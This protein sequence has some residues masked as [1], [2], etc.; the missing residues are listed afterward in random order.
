[1][2]R[3]RLAST[4]RAVATRLADEPGPL[5]ALISRAEGELAYRLSRIAGRLRCG[6]AAPWSSSTTLC[7]V[8][9]RLFPI[10]CSCHCHKE[11]L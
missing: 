8:V 4:L 10:R 2:I 7:A 3:L 6:C 11:T 5:S 9:D 1:M